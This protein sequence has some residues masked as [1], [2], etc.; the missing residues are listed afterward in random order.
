MEKLYS[1]H[2]ISATIEISESLLVNARAAIFRGPTAEKYGRP[3]M[4]WAIMRPGLDFNLIIRSRFY[5]CGYAA[6]YYA[7]RDVQ[8]AT[9]VETI[10]RVANMSYNICN[11]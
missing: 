7:R 8:Y 4:S 5:R 3:I 6:R 9:F 2:W 11:T 1:A 10:R